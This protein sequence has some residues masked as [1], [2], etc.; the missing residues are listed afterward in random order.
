MSITIADAVTG[1]NPATYNLPVKVVKRKADL[2]FK[3]AERTEDGVL[4]SELIGVY[5]NYDVEIGQSANNV[6]D[7]AALWVKITSAVESH[8]ITMPDESGNKIFDCYFAAI[9]DE[10]VKWNS[11]Q[12]YFRNLS[13]SII[14]ISP[15]VTP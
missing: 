11:S 14:A 13:F 4:H 9:K 5:Y 12:N 6:A 2:L 8:K 3:T 1:Y 7:Y 10:A 15:A